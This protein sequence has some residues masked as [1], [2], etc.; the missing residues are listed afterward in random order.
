MEDVNLSHGV[1][2][3]RVEAGVT[4]GIGAPGWGKKLH[5][6]VLRIPKLDKRNGSESNAAAGE[7]KG[8]AEIANSL[9]LPRVLRQ[10]RK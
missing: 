4:S 10:Q 9:S 1:R 6:S 7:R 2:S 3:G 8:G 5:A